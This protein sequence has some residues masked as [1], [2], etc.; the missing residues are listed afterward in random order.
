MVV[1]LAMAQ[2]HHRSRTLAELSETVCWVLTHEHLL[3]QVWGPDRGEDSG[4]V[5]NI[6]K[7]LRRNLGDDQGSPPRLHPHRA[8]LRL[9]DGGGREAGAGGG[10]TKLKGRGGTTMTLICVPPPLSGHNA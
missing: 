7:R 3:Q 5:R 4:P 10:V 6:V 9:P 2:R 1:V 8:P